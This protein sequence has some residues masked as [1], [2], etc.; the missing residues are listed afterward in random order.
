MSTDIGF[1]DVEATG[2]AVEEVAEV[3]TQNPQQTV[4]QRIAPPA[5]IPEF[6]GLPVEHIVT[7]LKV[8]ALKDDTFPVAGLDDRV[9]LVLEGVVVRIDHVIDPS[10]GNVTRV[11][12][13]SIQD[14]APAAW[15]DDPNDDGVL[16]ARALA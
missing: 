15:S 6:E 9:R 5:G 8:S 2:Q 7:H 16:R 1:T 10:T 4:V 13:I 11:Q 3:A 14:V 12:Y